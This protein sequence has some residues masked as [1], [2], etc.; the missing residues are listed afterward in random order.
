M[1]KIEDLKIKIFS[2]GADK[3]DMLDMNSKTFIKGF[4]TNPSL[5]KKTGIKDYAAFAKDI[6]STIKK[7]PISFEVFSD[8]F[9]EMER[10]SIE[11][12]SWADNV[13]VKIPITN[14][15]K[16][17]SADLIKRLTE[18]KVKL[19]ITAIMTLDQIKTVVK[20]LNEKVPSIL[21]VFA[22]RI[23]DTGRDPIP[24]MKD[25]LNEMKIN[26]NSELLWASPRE[27]LN[28]IQADQIGC[29]IITVTKDIVNKLKLIN[30]DLNEHSLDTVKKFYN[31]AAEA[32]FKI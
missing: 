23:A 27:L 2:D 8:D 18:K 7:K 10:Q 19:N 28:I 6:L 22:G 14:T 11:I 30:Y 9:D 32:N 21:S 1:K 15:K 4:T 29:H 17:N 20:V 3:K 25:C 31:D 13:Y 24:I 26:S 12:A 5:M 16:Q